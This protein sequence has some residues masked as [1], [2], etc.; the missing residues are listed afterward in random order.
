MVAA[1]RVAHLPEYNPAA[2]AW[3][4][5]RNMQFWPLAMPGESDA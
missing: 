4:P 5:C 1:G 3:L 2:A